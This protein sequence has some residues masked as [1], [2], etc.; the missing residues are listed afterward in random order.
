VLHPTGGTLTTPGTPG[1]RAAQPL[2]GRSWVGWLQCQGDRAVRS[3]GSPRDS[4]RPT[5]GWLIGCVS[6]RERDDLHRFCRPPPAKACRRDFIGACVRP[7][8]ACPPVVLTIRLS[9]PEGGP[10]VIVIGIDPHMHTHSS[11]SR[12]LRREPPPA[13]QPARQ[14]TAE[15]SASP[16]RDHA[17]PDPRACQGLRGQE[18]GRGREQDRGD[19]GS[20]ATTLESGVHDVEDDDPT[21]RRLDGRGGLT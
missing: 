3:R 17:A 1:S 5:A 16:D 15:R 12:L 10:G 19:Q 4:L 20:Q 2:N 7:T 13:V 6:P 11:R 8:E 9:R 14:P 18:T 21:G